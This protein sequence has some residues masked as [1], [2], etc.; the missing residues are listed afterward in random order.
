MN[1]LQLENS[2]NF[3]TKVR[4][5]HCFQAIGVLLSYFGETDFETG[6]SR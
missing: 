3:L 6:L 5:L 1:T 4:I 2:E